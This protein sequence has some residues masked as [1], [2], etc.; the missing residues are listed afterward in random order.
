MRRGSNATFY[1][2]IPYS[3]DDIKTLWLTFAQNGKLILKKEKTDVNF[4]ERKD[5]T[6]PQQINITL[7]QA[8]TLKF[9]SKDANFRSVLGEVQCRILTND[10]NVWASNIHTF[11]VDDVLGETEIR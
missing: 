2:T 5:T 9:T 6:Q 4:K 7:T 8:E 10:G 3:K 1:F 11:D